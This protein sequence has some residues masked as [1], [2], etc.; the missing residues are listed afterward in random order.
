MRHEVQNNHEILMYQRSNK[1]TSPHKM[2][3]VESPVQLIYVSKGTVIFIEINDLEIN[4][5]KHY[6]CM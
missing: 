3:N 5:R 4:S 6:L 2:Y 1:F